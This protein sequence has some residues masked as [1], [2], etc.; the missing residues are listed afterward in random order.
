MH[1]HSRVAGGALAGIVC[2]AA[3]GTVDDA[4]DRGPMMFRL[5]PESHAVAPAPEGGGDTDLAKKLSNPVANL[6]SVPF[7]SNYDEGF[8]PKDSGRFLLNI[9]PV[10]PLTLNEDWNL[11]TRTIVP[12]V[13]MDSPA[14]GI[15]SAFGLGDTLQSFFF[16]PTKGDIIW[17]VGPAFNWPTATSDELGSRQWGVGPTAVVLRQHDGWTYGALANHVW[18]FAGEDDHEEINQTF[19]Q[20]FLSYTFKTATS[21]TVNTESTYDWVNDEWTVPL[22]GMVAQ[23]VRFG[24]LPVQFQVGGRYYADSPEGGPEWGVRFVVTFLFPK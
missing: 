18:S 6:I 10:I 24:K 17:G 8:G 9:Q 12:V 20:P 3:Q 5:Q 13:N 2:V 14:E 15:D 7:Q 1:G 21:V 22:N 23:I 19:L 16:S 4:F 11:I